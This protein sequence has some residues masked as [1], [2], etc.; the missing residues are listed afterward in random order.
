MHLLGSLS[1]AALTASLVAQTTIVSP[2][3]FATVEGDSNNTFPFGGS[4]AASDVRRY[5]QIHAD[6]GTTPRVITKLAFRATAQAG[7]FTGTRVHDIE[8]YMG[9]G[10]PTSQRLPNFQ[11]DLNYAAP[12]TTV[13]PRTLVTWGPQGQT[14]I[15]GPSP[16]NGSMDIVLATPFSYTGTRPLIWEVA[17]FGDVY[18]PTMAR[19]DADGSSSTTAMSSITGPGCAATG[20]STLMTHSYIVGDSAGTL[21]M[22]GTIRAA[23]PNV[24]LL[25]AIG[26]TN[27]QFPV[28]GLCSSL[29]TDAVSVQ[30]LGFSSASG[31]F[32]AHVP[33]G[34]IVVPNAFSGVDVFTQAFALDP[35]SLAGIP[36]T[37][38]DGRSSAIPAAGTTEVNL[39][40][41][42]WNSVGGT[43]TPWAMF[44]TST[45]G[46]GLIVE[47]THL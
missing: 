7:T 33:T 20:S 30:F 25:M 26:F 31:A 40:T 13:L 29:Y 2:A 42:L 10:L 43:T 18:T 38:S 14:V 27:P 3:G 1:V 16:F 45:V 23:P 22:N 19:V 39:V 21:M 5:M 47:F 6:L 35:L 12:K 24:P 34:A 28:P 32:T 15:P 36:F 9:E 46:Y 8:V 11:Y 4:T 17:Y 37:M 41:R 44:G